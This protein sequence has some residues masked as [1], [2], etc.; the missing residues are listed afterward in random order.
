M[1]PVVAGKLLLLPVHMADKLHWRCL[2]TRRQGVLVL[3]RVV[4]P[5]TDDLGDNA[6]A[7]PALDVQ[8]PLE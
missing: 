7:V 8:Q 6:S 5:H 4:A 3:M 2:I 1:A